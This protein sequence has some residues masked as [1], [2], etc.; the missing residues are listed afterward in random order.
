MPIIMNFL[1]QIE[2]SGISQ[3]IRESDSVFAYSGVLLMHTIGMGFVVGIS[4]CINLRVLGFAPAVRLSGMERFLPTLWVGFWINAV[5]GTILLA[6]E[7]TQKLSNPDFYVKMV[8]IA[9]AVVSVQLM[10]KY[11][12]DPLVDKTPPSG[13]IKLWA[14]LSLVFWAGAITSGRLLAYVGTGNVLK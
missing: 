12:R 4:A 2:Q 5:T 13:K 7:A 14:V 8:F 3:W 1:T 11:L 9:L 6:V 10:K